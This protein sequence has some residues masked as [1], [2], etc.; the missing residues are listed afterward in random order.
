MRYFLMFALLSVAAASQASYE[1]A[2][3]LDND[4]AG[5]GIQVKRYDGDTGAYFGSF[6]T[7]A[8]IGYSSFAV[9]GSTG[10]CVVGNSSGGIKRFDYSTGA[11]LGSPASTAVR[12]LT[13]ANGNFFGN[14]NGVTSNLGKINA[15][16]VYTNCTLP[17]SASW[18]WV[19]AGV[20]GSLLACDLTNGDIWRTTA[21][22]PNAGSWTRIADLAPGLFSGSNY[23]AGGYVWGSPATFNEVVCVNAV[24]ILNWIDF[25]GSYASVAGSSTYGISPFTAVTAIAP[26]HYGLYQ[27]GQTA[28]GFQATR[29]DVNHSPMWSFGTSTLKGP[30]SMGVVLAPEPGVWISFLVGLAGITLLRRRP[31]K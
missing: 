9:D 16:G 4:P 1:L 11:Y 29:Y 19:T 30:L 26:A 3:I 7:G 17:V 28:T 14:I 6:G 20:D 22:T 12:S 10:T 2:L 31:R 25:T 27:A 8:L 24:G 18:G 13:F 23:A 21:A 5:G 15:S